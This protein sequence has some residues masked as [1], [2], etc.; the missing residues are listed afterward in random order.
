[1]LMNNSQ[2]SLLALEDMEK[3]LAESGWEPKP[4]DDLPITE[5]EMPSGIKEKACAMHANLRRR[6]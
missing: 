5:E 2:I 6:V 1:M 3:E 4:E